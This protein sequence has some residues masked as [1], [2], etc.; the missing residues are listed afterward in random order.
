MNN[1][2]TNNRFRIDLAS[3]GWLA[4]HPDRL[5]LV[6][7]LRNK[8]QS[9][10]TFF[11]FIEDQETDE[12]KEFFEKH[13]DLTKGELYVWHYSNRLKSSK[14]VAQYHKIDLEEWTEGKIKTVYHEQGAKIKLGKREIIATTPLHGLHVEWIKK[15]VSNYDLLKESLTNQIKIPNYQKPPIIRSRK[16][17]LQFNITDHHFGKLGFNPETMAFNWSLEQAA[18]EYNKVI[19]DFLARTNPKQIAEFVL[20]TGNDLINIDSSHNTTTRGTPQMGANFWHQV[21]RHSKETVI[22]SIEKLSKIAP[23]YAY[24]IKGNHDKDSVFTL[25][26]AVEAYFRKIPNVFIKNEPIKRN[27]HE[28]GANAI[29]FAHGDKIKKTDIYKTMSLDEPEL[30]ARCK[31]R[32]FQVGHLHKNKLNKVIDLE[33]KDEMSGI[34][35]EICPSLSPVDQ[36]HHENLFIGNI[37]RSKGFV[38]HKEHGLIKELYYNL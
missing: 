36:W 1:N 14:E 19:D 9:E 33:F 18:A 17:S 25:G 2:K 10:E 13:E 4:N 16:L 11:N 5:K 32:S 28:F 27:Y 38:R 31:Y 24:F 7:Q 26:E 34:D 29:G 8:I 6:E 12:F 21:F 37:R 20:P 3:I 22:A 23:V 15:Q 35:V 30:F